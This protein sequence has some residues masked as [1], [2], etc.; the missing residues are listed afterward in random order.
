MQQYLIMLDNKIDRYTILGQLTSI[1]GL[2]R[3]FFRGIFGTAT[4]SFDWKTSM[5]DMKELSK[6][7]PDR[8]I[9][10]QYLG[11]KI[12][13]NYR[14]YYLNGM[15]QIVPARISFDEFDY[16]LMI[17]INERINNH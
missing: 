6:L 3:K 4:I 13:K 5:E 2:E 9:T 12:S 15:V 11:D 16:D 10:L 17:E 7:Y 1:S 8:V 14:E